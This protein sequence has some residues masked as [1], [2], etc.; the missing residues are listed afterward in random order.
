MGTTSMRRFSSSR[1]APD[2]PFVVACSSTAQRC[3]QGRSSWS[4]NGHVQPSETVASFSPKSQSM[5][6]AYRSVP[7]T[8][9]SRRVSVDCERFTRLA[10]TYARPFSRDGAEKYEARF[11]GGC[12]TKQLV[13]RGRPK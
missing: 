4:K 13:Y 8:I 6:T 5:R 7:V 9:A 1:A 10:T 2:Q 12:D 3:L 11:F